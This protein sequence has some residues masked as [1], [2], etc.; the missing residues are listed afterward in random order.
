[1]DGFAH[2]HRH[3]LSRLRLSAAGCFWLGC[4]GFL[5]AACGDGEKGGAAATHEEGSGGALSDI[6]LGSG[7]E[8]SN[9]S[10]GGTTSSGSGGMGAGGEP[11]SGSGGT[12]A[13]GGTP[14]SDRCSQIVTTTSDNFLIDDFEHG[15]SPALPAPLIGAWR[16]S[17]SADGAS[18]AVDFI[19]DAGMDGAEST[20]ARI[21]CQ[22]GDAEEDAVCNEDVYEELPFA[23]LA[24]VL[25]E[26]GECLDASF[27]TGI[28]FRARS[29]SGTETLQLIVTNPIERVLQRG[30]SYS[31]QFTVT[32]S[33]QT[34]TVDF[35]DV[36]L[37][38]EGTPDDGEEP[39]FTPT[40][41][42]SIGF[43]IRGVR[44][45]DFE[46]GYLEPYALLIDDV[47]FY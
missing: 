29:E 24:A 12:S 27:A 41:L 37:S 4:S 2:K 18:R 47:S 32:E 39:S 40:E 10:S 35:D 22:A 23:F 15:A 6:D 7:G 20:V 43:I 25:V 11:P 26:T 1:M 13:A 21:Q 38:P 9:Q 5:L 17:S 3:R 16:H 14:S 34:F 31:E 33:W 19:E 8:P 30:E 46:P 28:S 45:V 42:R 44:A 36:T